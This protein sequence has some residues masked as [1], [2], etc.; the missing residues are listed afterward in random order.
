MLHPSPH[1]RVS[2]PL[3]EVRGLSAGYSGTPVISG[4]SFNV[5]PEDFTAILGPSGAGKSTLL[6]A[7]AGTAEIYGGEVLFRGEP[8][9]R[10]R[11]RTGYVPQLETIDWNFPL[12]VREAVMMGMTR[13]SW[14]GPWYARQ[15]HERA[16]EIM[17]R[18]GIGDYAGAHIRALSGGQ[19]QRVFLARALVAGAEL[20]LLDEPTAGID[21]KSRDD[22][23][24]LLDELNHEGVAILMA[25]HEINA[26]AAHLPWVMC[27]NRSLI[28]EGTPRDVF[29]P[30]I[31]K[32]TYG[33]DM[34][35]TEHAGITMVAEAPHFFGRRPGTRA[36]HPA[37][38]HD[39]SGHS[40]GHAHGNG[41]GKAVR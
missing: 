17:A 23:L 5:Y 14:F 15:Q 35:V 29:R 25:T 41:A 24:H 6:K 28:A 36:E 4:I 1:Q 21:V 33:A 34:P 39:G 32:R 38:A 7:L 3:V 19:Q 22:V 9:T 18:L 16:R 27:V 10:R 13:S 11:P 37:H 31:L 40:H 12:T 26:V 20:L 2:P 8:I 30:E